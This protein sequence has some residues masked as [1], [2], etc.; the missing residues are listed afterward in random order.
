MNDDKLVPLLVIQVGVHSANPDEWWSSIHGEP[1]GLAYQA[2]A[3][4]DAM[5]LCVETLQRMGVTEGSIDDAIAWAR[6]RHHR[7]VAVDPSLMEP[8]DFTQEAQE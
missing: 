3:I 8:D 4:R 6:Q 1:V 2:T 5:G 7:T